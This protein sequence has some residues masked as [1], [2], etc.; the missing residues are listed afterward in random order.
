VRRRSRTAAARAVAPAAGAFIAGGEQLAQHGQRQRG[1]LLRRP[2]MGAQRALQRALDVAMRGIPRQIV[3]PVHFT[4][5]RQP[6]SDCGRR[7]AAGK[8]SEIGT[9]GR[10][11]RRNGDEPV[12]GAPVG[13][14]G[15]VGFVGAHV[16]GAVAF[17]A[18]AWAASSAAWP[19]GAGVNSPQRSLPAAPAVPCWSSPRWTGWRATHA[20]YCPR[21]RA[22]EA[23]EQPAPAAVGGN[24]RPH[25]GV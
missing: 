25:D 23:E 8:T 5:R 14:M 17:L 22:S 21:W 10:R 24:R 4:Q 19:A 20:S 3:E 13:R 7:V 6:P 2:G 11:R 1:S 18:S 15:P 12:R 16:A 9:H